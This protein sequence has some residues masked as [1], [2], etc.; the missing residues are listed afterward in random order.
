M[1]KN[2][3]QSTRIHIYGG[4]DMEKRAYALIGFSATIEN[5]SVVTLVRGTE[6]QIPKLLKRYGNFTDADIERIQM[7]GYKEEWR[8]DKYGLIVRVA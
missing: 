7:M 4:A 8:C 3:W 6:K 5:D 2:L 1:A